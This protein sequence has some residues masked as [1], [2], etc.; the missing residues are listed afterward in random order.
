MKKFLLLAAVLFLA[1]WFV[2]CKKDRTCNCITSVDGGPA[3][4]TSFVIKHVT[5]KQA[6]AHSCVDVTQ[7]VTDSTGTKTTVTTCTLAK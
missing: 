2:S 7:K 1:N 3:T 6:L 5:K 4:N